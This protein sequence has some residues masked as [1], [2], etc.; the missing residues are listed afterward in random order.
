[1][2]NT[3]YFVLAVCPAIKNETLFCGR[4]RAAHGILSHQAWARGH[5]EYRFPGANLPAVEVILQVLVM[6]IG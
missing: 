1:M 4:S 5:F 6:L 3:A 2:L